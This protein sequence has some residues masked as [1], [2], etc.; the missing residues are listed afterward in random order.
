[1]G[2]N[3]VQGDLPIIE[4][5]KKRQELRTRGDCPHRRKRYVLEENETSGIA[6]TC[7]DEFEDGD[8]KWELLS[9]EHLIHDRWIDFCASKY[10]LPD[11]AELGPFYT[12]SRLDYVVIVATDEEGKFIC[13]RQF[14]QGIRKVTTEFPAGGVEPGEDP[15]VAAVREL[16]EETGYEVPDGGLRQLMKIPS[17]ATISDNYAFIFRAE[18][19][20]KVSSQELDMA[21]FVDVVVI[22]PERLARLIAQGRFDQAVHVMAY[23]MAAQS[24]AGRGDCM[25]QLHE[26][27]EKETL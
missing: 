6:E 26:G 16:R 22:E 12:Y 27:N 11:G 5:R 20:R 8:L 19:C 3:L 7:G 21:E 1:M 24:Q 13:V 17:N 23:Y 15:F 4:F 2:E 10:R 14:R 9:T 18:N 25:E